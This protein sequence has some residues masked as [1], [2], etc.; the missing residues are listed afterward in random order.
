MVPI[1]TKIVDRDG[2]ILWEYK[3]TPRTVL[4]K[5]VSGLV[6]E[7]LRKVMETGTGKGAKDAVRVFD[8]PIPS[9]GKTG[10]ANRFTNSSFVGFIPGPDDKTGQLDIQRGYVI[11]SYVGYDDNRPMKGK[12]LEIYGASGAMPLWIDTANA[13]V[14]T[15]DYSKNLQP[16]DLVFNPLSSPLANDGGFMTVPVSPYTGLPMGSSAKGADSSNLPN[17]LAEVEQRGN[18]WIL[19]RRFEPIK[20]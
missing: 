19:K 8:I 9:F 18:T 2:E 14:N 6:T 12:H 20:E 3:P 13:I 7:I 16:A 5:R 10:T 4:S 15:T 11:A 1:I 17:I